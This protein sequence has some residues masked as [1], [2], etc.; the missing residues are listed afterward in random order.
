ML[1]I[2]HLLFGIFLGQ[3]MGNIPLV[4]IGS[5]IVDIDHIFVYILYGVIFS[6]RKVINALTSPH[7]VY[8]ESRTQIHSLLIWLVFT[9]I[10]FAIDRSIAKFLSI[11]YLSHLILD[12]IDTQGLKLVWPL[13]G[14]IKGPVVYNS[15]MEYFFDIM[16]VALVVILVY[17]E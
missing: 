15:Q 6:P 7:D 8:V 1:L 11:G 10:V 13:K 2:T 12:S 16:L 5:I 4:T 14:V 17:I 3:L 9:L